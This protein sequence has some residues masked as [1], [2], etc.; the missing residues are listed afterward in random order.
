MSPFHH[1]DTPASFPKDAVRIIADSAIQSGITLF[2]GLIGSGKTITTEAVVKH[3]KKNNNFN[4]DYVFH[5]E[6]RKLREAGKCVKDIVDTL[7]V[8]YE[9]GHLLV[10][11]DEVN[12]E[13]AMTAAIKLAKEGHSALGITECTMPISLASVLA[14]ATIFATD[15]SV[16]T[17][18][19]ADIL[20]NLNMVGL[21]NTLTTYSVC[22]LTYRDKQDFVALLNESGL[23]S[24]GKELNNLAVNIR[25]P[26]PL[27]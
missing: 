2:G 11:F 10:V 21:Q 6:S 4:R 5:L 12:N 27:S 22:N 25:H 19:T 18:V 14:G 1:P 16:K 24:V 8:D 9:D 3:V 15:D 13:E 26:K 17:T 7:M 20:E 23:V